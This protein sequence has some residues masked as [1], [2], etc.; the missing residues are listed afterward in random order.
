MKARWLTVALCSFVFI[1]VPAYG[2]T[3][4][5]LIGIWHNEQQST[6]SITA[7]SPG[8]QITGTYISQP[9]TP[10]QVFLLFG[11]VKPVADGTKGPHIIPVLL[12][13]Q[14]GAYGTIT[15]WSGYLSKG[16][17]GSLSITTIWDVVRAYADPDSSPDNC[18]VNSAVFKPG[19]AH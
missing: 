7:I 1:N 15:V 19:P 2:Q 4:N 3:S 16:K 14:G 10:G 9:G 12:R 18:T 5:D 13:V 6:V 17:D 11:W 8:G